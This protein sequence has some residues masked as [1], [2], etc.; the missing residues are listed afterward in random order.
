MAPLYRVAC[1]LAL[2]ISTC[3]IEDISVLASDPPDSDVNPKSGHIETTDSTWNETNYDVRHVTDLGEGLGRTIFDV[4]SDSVDDITPRVGISADGDT[5]VVWCRSDD[6][7]L[8][9][10]RKHS[11]STDSWGDERAVSN[12]LESSR[13]PEIVHDGT[14]PWV[15]FEFDD[16]GDT[17][18]AVNEIY[19]DPDPI[20]NRIQLAVTDYV[21]DLDVLIHYETS[22]LWVTWVDSDFEVSW[23]E[24][25]YQSEAWGT[26]AY[27]SYSSDSVDHARSRI[28]TS[29]LGE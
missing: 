4:S 21:G 25:D 1:V 14:H 5:W 15:V 7:D 10:V 6:K 9:L 27:E 11:Y 16:A 26:P 8:V 12:R 23:C 28:R 17:G 24:Y 3:L 20:G 13:H 29:I 22:H 18:I 2:I 19:D